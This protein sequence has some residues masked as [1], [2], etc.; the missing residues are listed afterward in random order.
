MEQQRASKTS[1]S[2]RYLKSA[3][4]KASETLE[5]QIYPV[6]KAFDK[7]SPSFNPV[8]RTPRR[9]RH[10]QHLPFPNSSPAKFTNYIRETQTRRAESNKRE[11]TVHGSRNW[12]IAS[13]LS[14]MSACQIKRGTRGNT[15]LA[16][17]AMLGP[18]YARLHDI[19]VVPCASLRETGIA[20]GSCHFRNFN[21]LAATFD[22]FFRF[23]ILWTL[24]RFFVLR[25]VLIFSAS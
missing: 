6:A 1:K 11:F 16:D 9:T 8:K 25:I 12:N 3:R 19:A 18:L 17:I 24:L 2:C 14:A 21:F 23:L 13:C 20:A 22:V 5:E 10:L 4:R 15:R 7:L